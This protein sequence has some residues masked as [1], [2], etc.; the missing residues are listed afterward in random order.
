MKRLLTFFLIA[1]AIIFALTFFT[2]RD[3]MSLPLRAG[4]AAVMAAFVTLLTATDVIHPRRNAAAGA[5]QKKVRVID[6]LEPNSPKVLFQVRDN[7]IYPHLNPKPIYEI[8]GNHICQPNS[9][10][11]AYTLKENNIHRGTEPA[12][13]WEVRD[14]KICIPLSNQV[15]YDAKVRYE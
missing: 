2:A 6:I 1:W 4:A 10:K 7:K 8:R 11:V 5:N 13:L 3:E 9:S 15:V 14:G 12:P